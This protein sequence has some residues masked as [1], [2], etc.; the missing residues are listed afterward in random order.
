MHVTKKSNKMKLR[1]AGKVTCEASV[2][3]EFSAPKS[4][5]L[6]FWMRAKWGESEKHLG[7]LAQKTPWKRLLRS[8]LVPR[9]HSVRECRTKC[10]LSPGRGR[11]GYE[12][13]FAGYRERRGRGYLGLKVFPQKPLSCKQ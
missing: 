10:F 11:S 6:Y 1:K 7:F 12:I 5:F 9:S 2:S 4:R 8:N 3:V 13:S